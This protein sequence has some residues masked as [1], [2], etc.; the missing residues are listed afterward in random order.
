M[1]KFRGKIL[2]KFLL[3]LIIA[4]I[5]MFNFS[6]CTT[7]VVCKDAETEET[8]CYSSEC[9]AEQQHAP[10]AEIISSYCECTIIELTN[11]NAFGKALINPS[12]NS[13][14]ISFTKLAVC[15]FDEIQSVKSS[16]NFVKPPGNIFYAVQDIYLINSIFRI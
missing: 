16:N 5:T 3:M 8:C 15:G 11:D 12:N 13:P 10:D 1:K 9:S 4:G 7:I 14:N 2:N 6:F